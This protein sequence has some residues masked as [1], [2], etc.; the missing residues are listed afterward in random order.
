MKQILLI[1]TLILGLA[2]FSLADTQSKPAEQTQTAKSEKGKSPYT[3]GEIEA[4]LRLIYAKSLQENKPLKRWELPEIKYYI[5]GPPQA[6]P[7]E[8]ELKIIDSNFQ[9]ISK[10]VNINTSRT[11]NINEAQI[12]IIYTDD[13]YETIRRPN[14]RRLFFYNR[15]DEFFE[16][17]LSEWK[18]KGGKSIGQGYA[19]N[20]KVG[21]FYY[22]QE[23]EYPKNVYFAEKS[24]KQIASFWI[25]DANQISKKEAKIVTSFIS[26][27]Y[28]LQPFDI[29][30]LK[31]LYGKRI[32]YNMPIKQAIPILAEEIYKSF[33]E[34]AS[35]WQK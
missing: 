22:L 20:G 2:S 18:A 34:E 30:Y 32:S 11:A 12:K 25:S 28:E 3:L 27:I 23:I 9:R 31:A 19:K 4:F 33:N 35:K 15:S 21:V 7:S 1:A 5:S 14:I 10:I 13:F 29:Y 16:K 6:L 17:T 8:K 26:D 24:S